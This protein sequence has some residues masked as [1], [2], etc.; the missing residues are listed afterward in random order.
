MV[1]ELYKYGDLENIIEY[2]RAPR[3]CPG[4]EGPW[5]MQAPKK[6]M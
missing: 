5:K 2:L 3:P 6:A 4:E 1:L